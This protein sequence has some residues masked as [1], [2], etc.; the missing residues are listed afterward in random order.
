MYL[1]F[2]P[3]GLQWRSEIENV[4]TPIIDSQKGV[5]ALNAGS[6]AKG[7]GLQL[8]NETGYP[9][10]ISTTYK[11][12]GFKSSNTEFE[13]LLSA[14]YIRLANSRLEAGSANTEVT[15]IMNYL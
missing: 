9:I 15:F 13:I 8:K 11:F 12:S 3:P 7:I 5:A 14:A 2:P 4:T 1:C 10:A 6:T